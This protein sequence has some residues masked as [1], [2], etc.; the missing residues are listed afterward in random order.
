MLRSA[1]P[2]S[3]ED[4]P[5]GF[6]ELAS[7]QHLRR[8]LS[9]GG[10]PPQS[11]RSPADEARIAAF[12]TLQ[13]LVHILTE[14]RKARLRG[15]ECHLAVSENGRSTGRITIE[16]TILDEARRDAAA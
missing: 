2:I 1:T 4:D 14:F 6:P 15:E 7:L 16:I 8:L 12:F 3:H 5:L 11:R 10:L 13:E 9:R